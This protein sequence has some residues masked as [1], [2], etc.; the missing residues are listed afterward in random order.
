MQ[1]SFKEHHQSAFSVFQSSWIFR[2]LFKTLTG[3]YGP[4][5][6]RGGS[7]DAIDVMSPSEFGNLA[8]DIASTPARYL[9]SLS[10]NAEKATFYGGKL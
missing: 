5:V 6:K 4:G 3:N 10:L 1:V 9:R 2:V 8:L 7:D